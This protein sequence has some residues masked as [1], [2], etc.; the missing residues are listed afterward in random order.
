MRSWTSSVNSPLVCRSWCPLLTLILG[1]IS[2]TADARPAISPAA[3]PPPAAAAV[4]APSP[5]AAVASSTPTA[6]VASSSPAAASAPYGR[7]SPAAGL[8]ASLGARPSAH[9][10]RG[11]RP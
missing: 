4:A 1:V 6:A 3:G 9:G 2:A 5:A 7:F 8:P 11:G 10:Y